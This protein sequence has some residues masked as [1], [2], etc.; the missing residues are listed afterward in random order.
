M[1]GITLDI[2]TQFKNNSS[3]NP[4][5]KRKIQKGKITFKK[6][7][8]A[9]MKYSTLEMSTT[10]IPPLGP[11]IH[12]NY[13]VTVDKTKFYIQQ[14]KNA[15]EL[16]KFMQAKYHELKNETVIEVSRSEITDYIDMS[17]AI[18]NLH[19]ND[20]LTK[21]CLGLRD[22]FKQLKQH[23]KI[24]NDQPKYEIFE[25]VEIHS[26]RTLNRAQVTFIFNYYI[27]L[28]QSIQ[29][30]LKNKTNLVVPFHNVH[31]LSQFKKYLDR[32]IELKIFS[33][34]DI[35]KHTFTNDQF[36]EEISSLYNVYK[37]KYEKHVIKDNQLKSPR[38]IHKI[39]IAVK[40]KN[41]CSAGKVCNEKTG[42]C[43]K[44]VKK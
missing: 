18:A 31:R 8:T 22:A 26:S 11:V 30:E 23:K 29:Q 35:Y 17:N 34:D 13:K 1:E 20:K 5:T 15:V 12:W 4:L 6:L 28:Q 38:Q 43:N 25:N 21:F 16:I 32:L 7:S 33:Y 36:C 44:V 2:C 19:I 40:C 42:R 24:V 27:D 37:S 39:K 10:Y 9:C 14:H 41:P 3:I